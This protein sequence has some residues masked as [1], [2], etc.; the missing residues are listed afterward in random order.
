MIALLVTAALA[1]SG[2][3]DQ[4]HTQLATFLSGA[5][6]EK[7]VDYAVLATR[8]P[9][10]DGYLA[11]VKAADPTSW[12]DAQKLALYVNAY[13]AY[14]LATILDSGPPASIQDLDA[15]KVWDTRRFTVAG[16]ELTLN[17]I[18]HE[19]ARKL[20]DGRVHSVLN[21]ASKGCPPL[22]PTPLTATNQ[23]TQLDEGVKRWARTNAFTLTGTDLKLSMVFDWYG[24]DFTKENH[25]D[26]AKVDGEAENAVWFLSRF[27][28]DATKQKLLSGTLTVGWQPYDWTLN[29]K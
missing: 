11:Q 7:G 4:N 19:H 13:N 5:V 28:D 22:P 2:P 9:A 6:T 21:C 23:A 14:T 20:A 3:F 18:E 29:R 17:Q 27:T 25:G 10:L 15:G 16:Q 12:T 24:D 26:L 8:R 1:D